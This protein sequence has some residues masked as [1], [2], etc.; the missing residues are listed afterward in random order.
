MRIKEHDGYEI[1]H[2]NPACNEVT[3]PAGLLVDI[4]EAVHI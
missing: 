1:M 3:L 4:P 2:Q